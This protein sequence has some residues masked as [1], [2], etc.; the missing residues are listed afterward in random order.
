MRK[1]RVP[2]EIHFDRPIT[3]RY[4]Q[5]VFTVA[6]PSSLVSLQA[7]TPVDESMAAPSFDRW[8][9]RVGRRVVMVTRRGDDRERSYLHRTFPGDEFTLELAPSLTRTRRN[10]RRWLTLREA[11]NFMGEAQNRKLREAFRDL[12][13]D[14]DEAI[15]D[16]P[17]SLTTLLRSIEASNHPSLTE[18]LRRPQ[19]LDDLPEARPVGMIKDGTRYKV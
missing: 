15:K 19:A 12:G 5:E 6:P 1:T 8:A 14:V 13:I 11:A 17:A 7:E 2:Y 4:G 9:L 3:L 16:P 10:F 18:G